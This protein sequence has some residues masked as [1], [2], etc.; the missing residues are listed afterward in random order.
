VQAKSKSART[1]LPLLKVTS[2]LSRAEYEG[3][4]SYL[5]ESSAILICYPIVSRSELVF[6]IQQRLGEQRKQD[7]TTTGIATTQA[8]PV[9]T[10]NLSQSAFGN[11]VQL[12]LPPEKKQL[13]HNKNLMMD[14][15]E[16]SGI[17]IATKA[18]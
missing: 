7:M 18:R 4:S 11:D 8:T 12:L 5:S 9:M 3:L 13:K 2:T 10:T 1:G 14:K 15:G 17:S 6:F 16:P